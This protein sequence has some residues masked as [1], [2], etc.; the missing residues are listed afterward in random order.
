MLFVAAML[1][2]AFRHAALWEAFVTMA[3]GGLGVGL[4]FGL[5]PGLIVAAVAASEVGAAMGLY[6]VVRTS[7]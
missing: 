5:M 1:F 7:A 6:Q 4:S 2:F 3:V